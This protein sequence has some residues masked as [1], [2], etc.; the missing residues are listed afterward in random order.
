MKTK[1]NKDSRSLLI[2]LAIGDG[3]ISNNNVFKLS[4]CIEQEDY[5][6]WKINLLNENGLKNNG[7]KYYIS[8]NGFNIGKKVCYSQISTIPF[9]KLLRKI[10]Y[11]PIKNYTKLINRLNDIGLAIWFMD[12]GHINNRKYSDGS[13][14]GFY[15]KISTCLPKLQCE[16]IIKAIYEKFNIKFYIF[17]EGR[18]E[19][20][21]SLCCGTQEGKKFIK[22]VKPYVLQVPSMSYKVLIKSE[23]VQNTRNSEDIV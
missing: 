3:T 7:L 17:H 21:F 11:K 9:I 20:S 2:A 13:Y 22:I 1:I 5:L 23:E 19:D 4:H 16:E 14:K 18:K 10:M 12:D 6:K 8:S 15:I